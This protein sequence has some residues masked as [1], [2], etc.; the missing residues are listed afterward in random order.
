MTGLVLNGL[1]LERNEDKGSADEGFR[2]RVGVGVRKA[3]KGVRLDLF[4]VSKEDF[5]CTFQFRLE[6]GKENPLLGEESLEG[7]VLESAFVQAVGALG[8]N[9]GDALEGSLDLDKVRK[10]FSEFTLDLNDR[11][12]SCLFAA[13]V[14]VV[15]S[16][17]W[18]QGEGDV[19]KAVVATSCQSF[20]VFCR[21]EHARVNFFKERTR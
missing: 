13:E 6:A 9:G 21:K 16:L 11:V 2:V 3:G 17:L 14:Y 4:G 5:A 8:G 15:T 19:L 20:V 18:H 12:D 10:V 7:L 1:E